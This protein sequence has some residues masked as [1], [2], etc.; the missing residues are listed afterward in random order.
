MG[1]HNFQTQITWKTAEEQGSTR[2]KT[3]PHTWPNASLR[4][5]QPLPQRARPVCWRVMKPEV[6]FP[7]DQSNVRANFM[8]KCA[9][10][11]CGSARSKHR[12]FAAAKRFEIM[13]S[14]AVRNKSGRQMA[15]LRRNIC[16]MSD[17]DG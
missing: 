3:R 11:K 2:V 15:E 7:G 14:G 9:E 13:M 12:H 5:S 8:E 6:G 10:V 17:T 4:M 16:K 1:A